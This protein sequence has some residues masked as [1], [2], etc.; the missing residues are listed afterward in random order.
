MLMRLPRH[1]VTLRV[2]CMA[3]TLRAGKA[4]IYIAFHYLQTLPLHSFKVLPHFIHSHFSLL[5][6]PETKDAG[7]RQRHQAAADEEKSFQ[8]PLALLVKAAEAAEAAQACV[9]RGM[10]GRAVLMVMKMMG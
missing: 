3:S 2:I 10:N 5:G 1:P 8:Q 4:N 6:H 9:L 7:T